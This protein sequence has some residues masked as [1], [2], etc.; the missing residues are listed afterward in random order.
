MQIDSKFR[1]KETLSNWIFANSIHVIDTVFYLIGQPIQLA[2]IKSHNQLEW[3]KNDLFMGHGKT[4]N[5]VLF[6]FNSN[7]VSP[8]GWK[9]E[10]KCV[11]TIYT[12]RP[13]EILKSC[14]RDGTS[15]II[16][17]T[18]SKIKPGFE[19]QLN[20]FLYEPIELLNMNEFLHKV[21]M[22]KK[23]IM[24]DKYEIEIT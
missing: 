9:I 23:T 19:K 15:D 1:T 21:T 7:W 11:E 12:L 22:Q 24:K 3:I 6:T 13:M 20:S 17:E 16:V 5:D 8:G 4:V 14:T 2:L 10:I 18:K